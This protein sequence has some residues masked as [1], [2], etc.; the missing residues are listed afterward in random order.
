MSYEYEVER[1]RKAE[2]GEVK[3]DQLK[4]VRKQI[5]TRERVGGER[6]RDGHRKAG[7]RKKKHSHTYREM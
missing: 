4:S 7:R 1:R 3:L 6:Q 2:G 5:F